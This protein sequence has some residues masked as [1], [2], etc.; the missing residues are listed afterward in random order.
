MKETLSKRVQLA[1]F[2]GKI[3]SCLFVFLIWFTIQNK[4]TLPKENAST[5]KWNKQYVNIEETKHAIWNKKK[6]HSAMYQKPKNT[7]TCLCLYIYKI[8]YFSFTKYINT[9]LI[10]FIFFFFSC[11]NVWLFECYFLSRRFKVA[12]ISRFTYLKKRKLSRCLQIFQ[13]I[14]SK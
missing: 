14:K 7:T 1:F 3:D 2:L 9:I 12:F 6:H 5:Q 13:L 4:M 8:V 11:Q 10:I